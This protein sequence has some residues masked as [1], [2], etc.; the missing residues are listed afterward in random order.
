MLARFTDRFHT[1]RSVATT[2]PSIF[3]LINK[4]TCS[5]VFENSGNHEIVD[6]PKR[7]GT[8]TMLKINGNK[9]QQNIQFPIRNDKHFSNF[10]IFGPPVLPP[11]IIIIYHYIVS[12]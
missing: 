2:N 4:S 3:N 6:L 5:S 9:E 11:S 12:I 10:L 1:N 8:A 7:N